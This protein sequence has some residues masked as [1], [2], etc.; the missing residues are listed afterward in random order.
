MRDHIERMQAASV[1][2]TEVT[3]GALVDGTYAPNVAASLLNLLDQKSDRSLEST[4][5]EIVR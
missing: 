5:A 4:Y 1:A 2:P 3:R